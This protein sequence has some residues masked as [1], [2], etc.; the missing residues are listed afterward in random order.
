MNKVQTA[1]DGRLL[2][3]NLHLTMTTTTKKTTKNKQQQKQ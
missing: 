2:E 1:L 3:C